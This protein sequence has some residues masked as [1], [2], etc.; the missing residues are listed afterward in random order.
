MSVDGIAGVRPG[1]SH[2]Q[3]LQR[4]PRPQNAVGLKGSVGITAEDLLR[5]Q[6]PHIAVVPVVFCN[7]SIGVD[8]GGVIRLGCHRR[9]NNRGAAAAAVTAPACINRQS[10]HGGLLPRQL[11]AAGSVPPLE[12]LT[13]QRG[14]RQLAVGCTHGVIYRTVFHTAAIWLEVYVAVARRAIPEV[15]V[16]V[17]K[18]E[19]LPQPADRQILQYLRAGVAPCGDGID[20]LRLTVAAD[21]VDEVGAQAVV[22][23]NPLRS[24]GVGHAD[25]GVKLVLGDA[26]AV[27]EQEAVDQGLVIDQVPA[28]HEIRLGFGDA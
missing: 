5:T 11:Y 23:V 27:L 1:G 16:A 13:G 14:N 15:V 18:E 19:C 9:R 17:E 28:H 7:V 4:F 20:H 22:R 8:P 10:A 12:C 24:Q 26:D 3:Q 21:A 25:K 2:Q 6:L